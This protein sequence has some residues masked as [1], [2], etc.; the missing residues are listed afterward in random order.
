[1]TETTGRTPLVIRSIPD[2]I[3]AVPY[4]LG[5]H[6]ADSIVVIGFGGPPEQARIVGGR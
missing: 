6:P 4:L 2:A 1:M 3:A 5:F